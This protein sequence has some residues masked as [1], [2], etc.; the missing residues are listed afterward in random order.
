MGSGGRSGKAGGAQWA[1]AAS[2][3]YVVA[4]LLA[5]STVGHGIAR[6]A[7]ALATS[8]TSPAAVTPVPLTAATA[9]V[10]NGDRNEYICETLTEDVLAD[11]A[12][13]QDVSD[14]VSAFEISAPLIMNNSSV[15][16]KWS[17]SEAARYARQMKAVGQAQARADMEIAVAGECPT[18]VVEGFTAKT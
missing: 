7:A 5:R 4:I 8:T 18:L 11:L 14:V 15:A 16:L 13:G 2:A 10:F 17:G 12:K 6:D 9:P 3:I 1:L